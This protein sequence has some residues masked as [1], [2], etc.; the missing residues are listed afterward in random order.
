ML[1][2]IKHI[3]IYSIACV[4]SVTFVLLSRIAF[5]ESLKA[6]N[7]T[8]ETRGFTTILAD[9][10]SRTLVRWMDSA[11]Y[12]C[13]AISEIC[14]SLYINNMTVSEMCQILRSSA[15]GVDFEKKMPQILVTMCSAF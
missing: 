9:S 6:Y 1:P 4:I 10:Y 5:A 3:I 15:I 12:T 2:K 7:T 8:D 11:V 14:Y 13:V